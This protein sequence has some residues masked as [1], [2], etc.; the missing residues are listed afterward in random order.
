M[1]NNKRIYTCTHIKEYPKFN[2]DFNDTLGS[3]YSPNNELKSAS[4]AYCEAMS[5]FNLFKLNP[6]FIK[7]LGSGAFNVVIEI[8]LEIPDN[9]NELNQ[10]YFNVNNII[11]S[12]NHIIKHYALRLSKNENSIIKNS[13]SIDLNYYDNYNLYTNMCLQTYY[14]NTS[15]KSIFDSCFLEKVIT[16]VYNPKNKYSYNPNYYYICTH[17][18]LTPIY[19]NID[20]NNYNKFRLKYLKAVSN[21]IKSFNIKTGLRY[22][23]W[24]I[25]NFMINDKNELVFVDT[26]LLNVTTINNELCSSHRLTPDPTINNNKFKVGCTKAKEYKSLLYMYI[27]YYLSI[28]CVCKCKT[29]DEYYNSLVNVNVYNDEIDK[30]KTISSVISSVS[31]YSKEPKDT[32]ISIIKSI[33]EDIKLTADR[34]INDFE[35]NHDYYENV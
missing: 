8:S 14:S 23:D 35:N 18:A 17:Y 24:K 16:D 9:I 27:S 19:K 28:I 26:D 10:K 5:L 3:F 25:S 7:V 11:Q 20:N 15:S 32:D 1:F 13:S 12:K 21:M 33:I 29:L 30:D 31:K 6:K 22:F 34:Y 2:I 4:F